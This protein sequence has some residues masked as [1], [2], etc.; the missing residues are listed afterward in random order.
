MGI[1][2]LR[3]KGTSDFNWLFLVNPVQQVTFISDDRNIHSFETYCF[4]QNAKTVDRVHKPITV[5]LVFCD[6]TFCIIHSFMRFCVV[7]VGLPYSET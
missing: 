7:W 2:F 1:S 4:V 6:P 3:W 5:N